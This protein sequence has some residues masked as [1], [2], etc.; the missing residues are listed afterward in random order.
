MTR[1]YKP[2][3]EG[4]ALLLQECLANGDPVH[5]DDLGIFLPG[6]NNGFR[7]IPNQMQRVF[8]AYV[9]EDS[10]L[11][12]KL[13]RDLTN[14]CCRG[15]IG[16][17]PSSRPSKLRISSSPV[18]P[19]TQCQNAA[20]FSPSYASLWSAPPGCRSMRFSSSRSGW[21]NAP[22]PTA[23][24]RTFNMSI[25]FPIGRRECPPSQQPCSARWW[26]EATARGSDDSEKRGPRNRVRA[27]A[28]REARLPRR[29]VFGSGGFTAL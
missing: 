19:G 16:P 10:V 9:Q 15:R 8:I 22:F 20:F 5:I 3:A 6:R 13:Y 29:K 18:S 14:R 1:E 25:C 12:R 7:F 27:A 28:I 24:S 21:T 11:A 17:A 4:F 2:S 26:N 23:S